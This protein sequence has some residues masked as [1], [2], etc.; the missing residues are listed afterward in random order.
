MLATSRVHSDPRA[1]MPSSVESCY[2]CIV[3]Y[4]SLGWHFAI[5]DTPWLFS[6][7]HGAL[8]TTPC[9]ASAG[10][11]NGQAGVVTIWGGYGT[12]AG[13]WQCPGFEYF[14]PLVPGAAHLAQKAAAGCTA[15]HRMSVY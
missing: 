13:C 3:D 9:A 2:R 14:A 12:A 15:A 7:L 10:D 5:L 1:I 8:I 11:L 4:L 6:P